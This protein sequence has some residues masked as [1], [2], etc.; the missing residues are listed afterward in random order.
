LGEAFYFSV[1]QTVN[2]LAILVFIQKVIVQWLYKI[3]ETTYL[4]NLSSIAFGILSGDPQL[5]GG[6]GSYSIAS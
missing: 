5:K 4:L 6:L 3:I 1:N 2:C